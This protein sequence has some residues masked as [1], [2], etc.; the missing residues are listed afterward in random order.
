MTFSFV[1]AVA[2]GGHLHPTE[3]DDGQDQAPHGEDP[4]D[5]GPERESLIGLGQFGRSLRSRTK[6]GQREHV[7]EH[8]PEVRRREDAEDVPDEEHEAGC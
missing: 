3:A 5:R 6:P 2:A 1:V 7:R 4:C 8:V